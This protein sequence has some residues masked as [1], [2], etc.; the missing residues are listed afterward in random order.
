MIVESW[1]KILP[2][3]IKRVYPAHGMDFP[4]EV[5]RQEIANF[6]RI[7]PRR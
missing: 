3:R 4:V 7:H 6:D 2:L 5:M 1:K